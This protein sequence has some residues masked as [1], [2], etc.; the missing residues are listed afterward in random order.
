LIGT[1]GVWRISAL[2]DA[3][4]WNDRTTVEDMDLAVRASLRGWKFIYAGNVKVQNH[5]LLIRGQKNGFDLKF[6]FC[7]EILI[8]SKK[9]S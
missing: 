8:G 3:G 6:L 5:I 2:I 1:A 7:P 9:L 4:G